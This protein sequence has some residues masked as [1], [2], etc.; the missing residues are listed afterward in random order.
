[1]R[2]S[3]P[4]PMTAA[5][6]GHVWER[7]AKRLRR[8]WPGVEWCG[9][10]AVGAGGIAH[11]H[12]LLAGPYLPQA[13]LATAWGELGGYPFV[14]LDK[15]WSAGVGRYVA[16]NLGAYVSDQGQGRVLI[17]RGWVTPLGSG[18][19]LSLPATPHPPQGP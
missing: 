2:A 13:A 19:G 9:V 8:E 17:S 12:V 4:P 7:F 5:E 14:K 15:V 6:L 10:R 3:C 18:G 16:S 1:M 11:V